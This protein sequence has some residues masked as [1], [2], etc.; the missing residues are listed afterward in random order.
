[1]RTRE[2]WER[3]VGEAADILRE[4]LGAAYRAAGAVIS[5]RPE[6]DRIAAL[7]AGVA[8][9]AV[10]EIEDDI[11]DAMLIGARAVDPEKDVIDAPSLDAQ[12]A[13]VAKRMDGHLRRWVLD[14]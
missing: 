1:M 6:G 8:L 9:R 14:A 7:D 3:L 11:R 2:E 13:K 4:P 10:R 5:A 12:V